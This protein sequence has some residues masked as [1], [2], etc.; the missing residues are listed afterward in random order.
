MGQGWGEGGLRVGSV[1]AGRV[2]VGIVRGEYGSELGGGGEVWLGPR[3]GTAPLG[4]LGP[5]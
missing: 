4:V 3:V 1:L 2:R 5:I